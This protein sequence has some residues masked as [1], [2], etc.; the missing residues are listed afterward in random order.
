MGIYQFVT[1]IQK[2]KC[3]VGEI[4][5]PLRHETACHADLSGPA[6]FRM[7]NGFRASGLENSDHDIPGNERPFYSLPGLFIKK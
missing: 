6:S 2:E 5:E 4:S 7:E 3:A 1:G